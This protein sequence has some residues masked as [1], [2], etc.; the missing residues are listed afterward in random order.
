MFKDLLAS[1]SEWVYWLITKSKQKL[2]H[3]FTRRLNRWAFNL[4]GGMSRINAFEKYWE[5][6]QPTYEYKF[7]NYLDAHVWNAMI[8]N[9]KGNWKDGTV[10]K[11]ARGK[12]W[13]GKI[14]FCLFLESFAYKTFQFIEWGRKWTCE[15][16]RLMIALRTFNEEI[17]KFLTPSHENQGQ[18]FQ[19]FH[20]RLL[21]SR[22]A[23]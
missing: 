6:L 8:G 1:R 21:F 19:A 23:K 2:F 18:I 20:Q 15:I 16:K 10:C 3:S 5:H 17:N 11:A 4:P 13:N 12:Y 22:R 14:E 9:R 7:L